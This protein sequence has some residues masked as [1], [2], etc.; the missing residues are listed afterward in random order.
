MTDLIGGHI[1]M[2]ID[3][4][5]TSLPQIRE[6]AIKAFAVTSSSRLGSAPAI[7]TTDEAD[8]P[9]FRIA[10]WHG[11][12]VPKGTSPAIINTLSAAAR[13]ALSD[14]GVSDRLSA[15]GQTL[16]APEQISPTGLAIVQSAEIGKWWPILKAANVK[17]E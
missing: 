11:L 17:P 13:E 6:G 9:N 8:L 2:M 7:P 5:T 1:D 14:S 10:V 15:L 3:Q 16:P 12:W 4:S